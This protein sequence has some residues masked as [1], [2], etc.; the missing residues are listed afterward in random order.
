MLTLGLDPGRTGAAV[1]VR[2]GTT[3]PCDV[4]AGIAW[5][6]RGDGYRVRTCDDRTLDVASLHEAI[7]ALHVE[8]P[9]EVCL[10]GL[11]VPS[12][13]RAPSVLVLAEAAGEILG[14]LRAGMV[15]LE[16][17]N[18]ATWRAKAF[19]ASRLK[20]EAWAARALQCAPYIGDLGALKDNEHACDALGMAWW[21][22][23]R[24]R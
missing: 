19:R 15:A 24:P 7:R 2:R 23:E 12:L 11:F 4:V 18:A 22:M 9:Y 20:A 16:R 21:M 13:S 6:P 8:A 5:R 14:P 3:L 10:E 17:P 1:A